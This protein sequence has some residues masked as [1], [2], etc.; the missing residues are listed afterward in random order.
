MKGYC[1]AILNIYVLSEKF[2]IPFFILGVNIPLGL[3]ILRNG[4]NYFFNENRG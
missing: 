4:I 3:S 2:S 1:Y